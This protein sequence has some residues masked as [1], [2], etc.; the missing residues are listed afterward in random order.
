MDYH[1]ADV[2]VVTAPSA[3]LEGRTAHF[4][5]YCQCG[6]SGQVRERRRAADDD[7]A[8]H[9]SAHNPLEEPE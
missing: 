4:Q 6:W 5:A 1:I 8:A 2:R 7:A 9:D 3:A